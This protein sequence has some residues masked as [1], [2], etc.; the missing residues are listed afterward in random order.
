MDANYSADEHMGSFV[1][2]FVGALASRVE[3]QAKVL[4]PGEKSPLKF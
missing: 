2:S 1:S 3:D 4:T